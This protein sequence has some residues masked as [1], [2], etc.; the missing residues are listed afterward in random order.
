MSMDTISLGIDV[1]DCDIQVNI[2]PLSVKYQQNVSVYR[3]AG[4]RALCMKDYVCIT[5]LS[6]CKHLNY[7]LL[8][9]NNNNN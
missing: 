3:D 5:Y 1:G 9:Q 4:G 2:L 6:S 7:K 8:A